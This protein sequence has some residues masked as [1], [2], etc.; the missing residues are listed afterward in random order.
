MAAQLQVYEQNTVA[1]HL[2]L[3]TMRAE[4]DT[5]LGERD[6]AK[7][8][9]ETLKGRLD[10]MQKAWQTTRTQLEER[11]SKYTTHEAQLK[12]LEDD[13][14][15]AN[16]CFLAFKQQVAQLLSDNF[17]KVEPVEDEVKQKISLLMQ[18]S[19]DRGIVSSLSAARMW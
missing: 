15:F 17:V 10:S 1:H 11:D 7:A 13:L 14:L 12:K 4:R 16:S 19:K 8:E 18:S 9:I 6:A 2:A 3:D 5:A